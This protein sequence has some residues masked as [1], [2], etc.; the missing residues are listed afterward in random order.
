M[1]LAKIREEECIGCGKCIPHCPVDAI[2]GSPKFLHTVL[3]EACIGCGLCVAPCP[4]D[5]I[6]MSEISI[7]LSKQDK[8]TRAQDAKQRYLA[9][10]Q[11][12]VARQKPLINHFS[13]DP[14]VQLKIKNEIN[15]AVLRVQ[16]R[17][18]NRNI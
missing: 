2:L 17:I 9:R 14:E 1:N 5:C 8:I 7:E 10:Q 11:R 13:K 6:D 15:N 4:V 16:Q 18:Q 12:L 3:E